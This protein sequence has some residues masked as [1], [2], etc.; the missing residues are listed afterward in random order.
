MGSETPVEFRIL[1]PLEALVGAGAVPLGPPKQRALLAT[2]LLAR[3]AVVSRDRLVDGLWGSDPPV[4]AVESLQVYVHKLRRALGPARIQTAGSGYRV[5]LDDAQLDLARFEREVERGRRALAAG[6]V[7]EAATGLAAA[8][9]LWRGPALADLPRDAPTAAE[10]ER[11]ED[12]RLAAVELRNDAELACGR[13]DGLTATLEPLVAEH[14][15]R[16]RFRE[17]QI[18]ALYRSGRQHEALEACRRARR[19]LV[20]DLGIE[21]GARLQELERSILRQ[22]PG[23]AAPE[24]APHRRTR[25]PVPPTPLVGRRLEIAAIAALLRD[26]ARLVTLT[27]TGGTGKTR[28]ALAVAAELEPELRDGALFVDLAPVSD[29]GLVLASIA[30]ALELQTGTQS[31]EEALTEHLRSMRIL[32]VLDNLEQLLPAAPAVAELLAAASGLLM[33]A[34]SRAPLRLGAEQ[35]YPVQ[36]LPI[37]DDR[38]PFEE[39]V[40]GDAI[41]LFEARA[42]AVNPGFRLDEDAA[43]DVARVCARLDG[44]PLAIE[45]AAARAKLLSPTEMLER[46]PQLLGPGPRD[47]PTRQRTL[48][49]TIQWS[50]DLLSEAERSAF[51][52]FGVFAG[53]ATIE[54]AERLCEAPLDVLAGLVDH[55]LLQQ[56]A[57]G[58]R[59]TM[60]ETVRSCAL[61]HLAETGADSVR[62]RHAV[63]LTELAEEAE[64]AMRTGGDSAFWLDRLQA[65]HDNIRAAL[66]WTLEAGEIDLALRLASALRVFWEVRGHFAEGEQW[67][68]QALAQSRGDTAIRARALSAAGTAAFRVGDLDR[69]RVRYTEMLALWREVGDELGIARGLS[70]LGTVAAGVGDL[71]LAVEMLEESAACFRHLDEPARLAIVLQNLGHVASE[72]GDYDEAIRVTEEA[73]A[74]EQD[75]G[76]KPN[77]AITRYNLGSFLFKAGRAEEAIAWLRQCL[78]L[79]VALDYKEVSAYALATVV[80]IRLLEAD[81]S[82]AAQLSGVA[83]DLLAVAGVSLQTH[84]QDA[85]ERAKESARETLGEDAY[86]A[87]HAAGRDVPLRE[88]LIEAGLLAPA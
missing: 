65:E 56:D 85:F 86:E 20:D 24:R 17:Q 88:A 25:L 1:G 6:E 83:D 15:Y 16:E 58:A 21:P 39:L 32:L 23:L 22:E 18:L 81:A 19:A 64:T 87:A 12:L 54:A 50:Y 61:E 44:L 59:L 53:G 78:E 80:Q 8:L 43:R 46:L 67:L 10:A 52:Q 77:E 71:D 62:T 11:L 45:L 73:L 69:A 4:S 55:S 37:P 42:R 84:E 26:D 7:E 68:D 40:R 79:T 49:A 13:H 3:G 30:E 82:G 66:G 5:S 38:L 27:G 28:V 29:A 72:R 60:L 33:L 14:P 34:T 36:P 51:A 41:R 35:E 76:F 74:L 47:A 75:V 2:L 57:A 48:T 9:A 31:V 63:W 70:D